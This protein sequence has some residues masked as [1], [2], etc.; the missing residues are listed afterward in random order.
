MANFSHASGIKR[1][2][3]EGKFTFGEKLHGNDQPV[4]S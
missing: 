4:G 1:L 2:H 3:K